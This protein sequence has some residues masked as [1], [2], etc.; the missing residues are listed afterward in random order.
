M[1]GS[2]S[3]GRFAYARA[4]RFAGRV[5]RTRFALVLLDALM[6]GGI[7]MILVVLRFDARIPT[8]YWKGFG[9][10][11]AAALAVHLAVYAAFGLYSAVWSLASS[12]EARRVLSAGS[13]SLAVMTLVSLADRSAV[14]LSL[15]VVGGVFVTGACGL[16]RFQSRLF[17]Q[18]RSLAGKQGEERTRVAVIGAGSAGA[19]VVRSMLDEQ[20]HSYA[21]VLFLD[22]DV[23]KMGKRILG[24][25]VHGPV[26]RISEFA[27]GI[28]SVLIALPTADSSTVRRMTRI[29]EDAS[30]PLKLVPHIREILADDEGEKSVSV[31]DVRDLQI[32]DLLGRPEV[33]TDLDA[34]RSMIKGRCV[35]VTGGG[36]SIGS[37]I[38]R[39]ISEFEPG[40]LLLLDCDETHLHDARA[41]ID[42]SV[43]AESI[44]VNV[45]DRA[46][47]QQVFESVRPELVLHAAALKHVPV[48]EDHAD[49]AFKTNIAG[50]DA[51]FEAAA[52][53]GTERLVFIST[54]KAVNPS[55]VMGATKW[56]GEQLLIDRAPEG[57]H[58]SCVR[59]GN[60][61]G[62][63]GSVL[64]TFERQIRMGGPVTVTDPNMTRFFM[65]VQEAV[66]LVLQA[67][68][69]TNGRNIFMLDMG[70]PAGILDLAERMIRLTGQEPGVD[71]DIDI[72]GMRPGEKLHEELRSSHEAV[73]PTAH[74]AVQE[75]V[76]QPLDSKTLAALM[77]TLS[78]AVVAEAPNEEV[79]VLIRTLAKIG[80]QP[81]QENP[82]VY[83]LDLQPS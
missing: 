23:R 49:E 70:E 51:V 20:G 35:V 61:L 31:A 56:F 82:P 71:I 17:V 15:P 42:P 27:D 76:P 50:T 66:Q 4:G 14:P 33:T 73:R 63:R 10:F 39:Q 24:L 37:E 36:G 55:S 79:G 46:R 19:Q 53:V 80:Q 48:L 64:P 22:D 28:D 69:M 54:D 62:S 3:R 11:V 41:K 21:P 32:N 44:L 77:H 9:W 25:P 6:I 60:V 57:A 52:S 18:R 16:L 13:L 1:G 30:L 67:A 8:G 40:R 43:R 45:R 81:S 47:V 38:A 65:S 59:F 78:R 68:T 75:L 12:S 2:S 83:D 26:S 58:W 29:V 74:P 7:Y 72:T 34:V 5:S